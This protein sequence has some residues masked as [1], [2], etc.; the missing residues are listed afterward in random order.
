MSYVSFRQFLQTRGLDPS[1]GVRAL[2]PGVASFSLWAA[3]LGDLSGVWNRDDGGKYYISHSQNSIWWAGLSSDGQ[4]YDGLGYTNVFSGTINGNQISGRW[5]DVPR[6]STSN[7]GSFQLVVNT[8]ITGNITGLSLTAS[9]SPFWVRDVNPRPEAPDI[10]DVFKQVKKNQ[11]DG[12]E[13]LS[14]NLTPCKVHPVVVFGMIPEAR[15]TVGIRKKDWDK[16]KYAD[17]INWQDSQPDGD[18]NFDLKV[19]QDLRDPSSPFWNSD[20][21]P[22]DDLTPERFRAKLAYNNN[23]KLHCEVIMYGRTATAGDDTHYEDPPLLPGWHEVGGSSVL[24]NGRPID[25]L[26][27]AEHEPTDP[28]PDDHSLFVDGIGELETYDIQ[29]VRRLRITGILALDCGHADWWNPGTYGKNCD[30]EAADTQ[31]QEIHPV[32]AIDIINATPR[33]NLTGAWADAANGLTYYIRHIGSEIW[34]LATS[35][36]LDYRVATVF[37]GTISADGLNVQGTFSSIPLGTDFDSSADY[38]LAFSCLVDG[39]RVNL[40][41]LDHSTFLTKLYDRD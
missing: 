27:A 18:L 32:L 25:G 23:D 20:W 41:N 33:E 4:F 12:E 1:Q 13:T 17:F 9:N 28:A 7:M 35:P 36:A 38:P 34:W 16:Q 10:N 21:Q 37:Q 22:S 11:D 8:D 15:P 3:I 14:D 29:G 24:I 39:G 6:G 5:V 19:E 26:L 31:N 30:E 40:L 2:E